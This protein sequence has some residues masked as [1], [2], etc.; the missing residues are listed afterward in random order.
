MVQVLVPVYVF[1]VQSASK[2]ADRDCKR[3]SAQSGKL[4][5]ELS[6]IDVG[7]FVNSGRRFARGVA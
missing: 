1:V 3:V 4:S 5:G 6:T 7:N 2:T